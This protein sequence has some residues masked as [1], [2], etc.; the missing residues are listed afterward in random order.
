MTREEFEAWTES[1]A[2]RWVFEAVK[3]AAQLQKEHWLSE[4][5]DGEVADQRELDRCKVRAD[6]YLALV[7]TPYE[8]FCMMLGVE[9]KES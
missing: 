2:T 6:A 7:E 3:K 1:P 9:P 8:R 4:S 5:W